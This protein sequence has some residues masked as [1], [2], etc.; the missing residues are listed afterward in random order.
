MVI[1]HELYILTNYQ[2]VDAS[3]SYKVNKKGYIELYKVISCELYMQT[4]DK[5]SDY[6]TS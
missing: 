4:I 3:T 5:R 6:S 1:L 2:R